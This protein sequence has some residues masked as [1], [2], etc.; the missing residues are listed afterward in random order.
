MSPLPGRQPVDHDATGNQCQPKQRLGW[1][2]YEDERKRPPHQ[3][4]IYQGREG[5]GE[6]AVWTIQVRLRPAQS[7]NSGDRYEAVE[8]QREPG[9]YEYGF[10][11]A[12]NDENYRQHRLRRDR[13]IRQT[14]GVG[15]AEN[16]QRPE[17]FA[18]NLQHSRTGNGHGTDS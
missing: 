13:D 6:S 9:E 14:V 17:V 18:N 10:E 2:T 3:H 1:P 12:C 15:L 8:C 16:R 11:T 7:K 5:I 4:Q